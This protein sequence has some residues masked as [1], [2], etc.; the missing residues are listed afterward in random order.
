MLYF[1]KTERANWGVPWH[2]D[3]TI[4]V[5]EKIELPGFTAWS[6]KQGVIHVHRNINPKS[7][8]ANQISSSFDRLSG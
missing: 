3:K 5:R 6:V 2:Q 4:A 8:R 7:N 1:N